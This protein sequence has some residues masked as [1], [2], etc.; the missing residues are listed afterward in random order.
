MT[1]D[2]KKLTQPPESLKEAIDWVLR[3][4]GRDSDKNDNNAINELGDALE[5]LLKEEAGDVAVRVQEVFDVIK[6]IINKE[7]DKVH[8]FGPQH[9]KG[10]LSS[11][12]T[13]LKAVEQPKAVKSDDL[14]TAITALA[15]G[16]KKFLGYNGGSSTNFNGNGI[17]SN[18][19][20]DY[21]FAYN[22]AKWIPDGAPKCGVIF[23]AILPAI[24]F[25][26][27]L[28]YWKCKN[29]KWKTAWDSSP[30]KNFLVQMGYSNE[31]LNSQKSGNDI[32]S[33]LQS[34]T[35]LST[36]N[37]SPKS[38]PKFLGERQ[39]QAL[40]SLVSSAASSPLT[41]L[42][43]LSYYYITYP[44]YDVHSSNPATPSFAG[45]SGLTALAGGAY[46]LNLGGLGTFMSALL[47]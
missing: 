47:A 9:Y 4:S 23:L 43:A 24:F 29:N 22:D 28:T 44:F 3:V 27:T 31:N 19:S 41:S 16:L 37:A 8:G 14:K 46:R 35:E 32:A 1:T 17:I 45:N 15:E 18:V 12:T 21:T 5:A 11:A 40:Q 26:V 6:N 34:F 42:Y 38:Y 30:F 33:L 7:F 25:G 2:Q 10:N 13:G 36:G 20:S 39:K